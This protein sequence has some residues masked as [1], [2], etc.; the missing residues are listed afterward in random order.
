MKKILSLLLCF[1]LL[2]GCT[3]Q[4]TE[5]IDVQDES[6]LTKLKTFKPREKNSVLEDNEEYKAFIDEFCLESLK[7]MDYTSYAGYIAYPDE[8]E[9]SEPEGGLES[10]KYEFDEESYEFYETYLNKLREFDYDSLSKSQQYEYEALEYSLMETLCDLENWKYVRMF[11]SASDVATNIIFML[12]DLPINSENRVQKYLDVLR[13]IDDYLGSMVEF[14]DKQ[15]KDGIYTSDY[16][17]DYSISMLNSIASK[18]GNNT[19]I[20][21]FDARIDELD[22]LSEDKKTEYKEENKSIVF[23]EI[24]PAMSKTAEEIVRFKGKKNEETMIYTYGF[25][26]LDSYYLLNSSS[27]DSLDYILNLLIDVYNDMYT[28]YDDT[29][30][31]DNTLNRLS[32]YMDDPFFKLECDEMIEEM[33][34][35]AG[36]YFKDIGDISFTIDYFDDSLSDTSVLAYYRFHPIDNK[37]DNV[38]RVNPAAKDNDEAYSFGATIAHEG[39]PGHMYNYAYAA[40]SGLSDVHLF[41]S[42]TAFDEGIAMYGEYLLPYILGYEDVADV[43]VFDY[44]SGYLMNSIMDILINYYAYDADY[45]QK[46][47]GIPKEYIDYYMEMMSDMPGVFIR[48]GVGFAYIYT[49]M[50][51][52]KEALGD[53]F[54]Y[55]DFYSMLIE[56][57]SMPFVMLEKKV[58]DYILDKQ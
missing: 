21:S 16:A 30:G 43:I 35:K 53:E 31:L 3:A 48:Y 29:Y 2:C 19:L 4:K 57:G 46:N 27:N 15:Y 20:E 11:S 1:L 7:M 23:N 45:I 13:D 55:A 12:V 51:N 41:S 38:I 24:L 5:T 10:V 56:N 14:T 25:D 22:F 37:N 32:E 8:C 47:F 40:V 44:I 26:Y 49:F 58:N 34:N 50:N 18:K 39:V 33:L 28:K 52:T 17:L 9:V 42:F 54:D 36:P 6:Y